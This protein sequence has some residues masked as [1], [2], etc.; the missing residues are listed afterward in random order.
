VAADC[1]QLHQSVFPVPG[2]Q[3]ECLPD[4]NGRRNYPEADTEPL[5]DADHVENDEEDEHDE[6]TSAKD[7]EVLRFQPLELNRT[8]D[9]LVDR[10][11]CHDSRDYKKNERRIVAATIKKIHA[12]NHDAAVFDV[13]G[14]PDEN[15]PY[16]FTPPIKPTTAPMA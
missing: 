12:P 6:Q 14:S 4:Q 8:A 3:G 10:E 11:L 1:A 13:S 7:E 2:V 16:T 9:P 15:L 5:V